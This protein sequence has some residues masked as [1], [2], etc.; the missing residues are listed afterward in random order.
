MVTEAEGKRVY[1]V[2]ETKGGSSEKQRRKV[3]RETELKITN[4]SGS[5]ITRELSESYFSYTS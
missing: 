2:M 5:Y 3:N 4:G 1:G